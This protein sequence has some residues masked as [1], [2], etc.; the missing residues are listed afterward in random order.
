MRQAQSAEV[1]GATRG[2]EGKEKK[3][4]WEV[5]VYMG[6][7]V[8]GTHAGFFVITNI[9]WD[10]GS[11]FGVCCVVQLELAVTLETDAL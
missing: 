8:T 1:S 3:G 11:K 6:R 10:L 2:D 5:W 7:C 4:V 9:L